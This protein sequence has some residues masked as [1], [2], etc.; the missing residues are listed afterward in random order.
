MEYNT[1][2]RPQN[3]TAKESNALPLR[4][5]AHGK[6]DQS[7]RGL[8]HAHMFTDFRLKIF[9]WIFLD[10][11]NTKWTVCLHNVR[12]LSS[13]KIFIYIFQVV[14]VGRFH[15]IAPSVLYSFTGS[16]PVRH[17]SETSA[18]GGREG[19]M[20]N[21]VPR[22]SHLTAPRSELHRG[23][24]S[25]HAREITRGSSGIVSFDSKNPASSYE[26]EAK[27]SFY[28]NEVHRRW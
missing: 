9:L 13:S 5:R 28:F 23:Q 21:I 4:L 3:S 19:D 20:S 22:V 8:L 18:G 2:I 7:S 17:F 10:Y 15:S 6:E 27:L 11:R 16:L 26:L 1:Y 12:F 24:T 14:V 25:E